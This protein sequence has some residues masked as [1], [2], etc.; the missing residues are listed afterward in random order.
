M[1]PMPSIPPPR[2]RA[3]PGALALLVAS[4]CASPEPDAPPVS[5]SD[6][7]DPAQGAP[8]PGELDDSRERFDLPPLPESEVLGPDADGDHVRDDVERYIDER[9]AEREWARLAARQIAR[10]F[11]HR[12]HAAEDREG[13]RAAFVEDTDGF[14]C[15]IATLGVEAAIDEKRRLVVEI[16]DTEPRLLA[17]FAAEESISGGTYRLRDH[18]VDGCR[19]DREGLS[20]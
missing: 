9:F 12:L 11:Q 2:R 19:F 15:L 7:A 20:P 1:R 10:A 3:W 18:S 6:G 17:Y 13:A 16:V 5:E 4:A 14:E 8:R